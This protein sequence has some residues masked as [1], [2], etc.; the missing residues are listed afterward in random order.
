MIKK[1]IIG[2]ILGFVVL[3]GPLSAE[4]FLFEINSHYFI[5][6]EQA[7]KDVYGNGF[8][9]GAELAVRVLGDLDVWLG[10]D[11]FLKNGELTFTK[12]ETELRVIP[13]MAGLKYRLPVGSFDLYL[14]A[15]AS[16]CFYNEE[17]ALGATTDSG[18]GV[19]GRLGTLIKVVGGLVI[20]LSFKYSYIPFDFPTVDVDIGG[21]EAGLGIGYRF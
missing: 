19:V 7:F 20:D 1:S 14:A 17:S 16:Y 10:G 11:L 12:E 5:P 21:L 6:T 4:N 3:I 15:G 2:L 18:I 8:R 13:V 9:Y